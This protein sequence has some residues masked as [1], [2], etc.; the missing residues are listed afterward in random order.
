M[1]YGIIIRPSKFDAGKKYPV[2]EQIY[3]GPQNFIVPKAFPTLVKE[4]ELADLGFVS[5][6]NGTGTNWRSKAFYDRCYKNLKYAG[7]PDRIAWEMAALEL[8][9]WMDI[10]RVGIYGSSAGG[11]SAMG[12]LLW[13]GNFYKAAVAGCG[14]HDNRMDK[15]RWNE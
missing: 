2:I 7:L 9:P 6:V 10:N 13:H 15:I 11:Q 12:A 3:G 4:H 8:R 5:S 1:I 14:C